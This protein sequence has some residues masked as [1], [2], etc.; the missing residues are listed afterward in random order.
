MVKSVLSA[1]ISGDKASWQRQVYDSASPFSGLQ[2]NSVQHPLRGLSNKYLTKD[3][4]R[5]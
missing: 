2:R 3:F 4:E 5:Q 1:V